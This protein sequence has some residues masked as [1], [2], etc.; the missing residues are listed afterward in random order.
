MAT[1]YV[2]VNGNGKTNATRQGSEASRITASVQSY[3]G[4]LTIEMTHDDNGGL[5]VQVY[6]GQGSKMYGRTVYRGGIDGFCKALCGH[7]FDEME[8]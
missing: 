1:F 8:G 4:S 6:A 7:T 5:R 3:D 2:Q